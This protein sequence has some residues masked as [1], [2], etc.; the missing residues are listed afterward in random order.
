[1]KCDIVNYRLVVLLDYYKILGVLWMVMFVFVLVR[2][3]FF[4]CVLLMG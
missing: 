2:V 3:K 1:M 4:V